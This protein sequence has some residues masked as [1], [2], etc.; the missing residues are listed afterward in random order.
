MSARNSASIPHRKRRLGAH[1]GNGINPSYNSKLTRS[2]DGL[3]DVLGAVGGGSFISMKPDAVSAE[4][5]SA[6]IRAITPS[7]WVIRFP[8][9]VAQRE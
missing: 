3:A 5:I 4:Q 9:M 8:P 7:A 6:V 1:E 2:A